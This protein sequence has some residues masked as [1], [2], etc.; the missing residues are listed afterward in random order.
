MWKSEITLSWRTFLFLLTVVF[1]GTVLLF[2]SGLWLF[3]QS[4][5]F[6][7][8]KWLQQENETL[9]Q[10]EAQFQT[11]LETLQNSVERMSRF[12]QKLRLLLGL[13]S[14][15]KEEVAPDDS[16]SNFYGGIHRVAFLKE[17]S[18]S[19][20]FYFL[21]DNRFRLL[22]LPT[23]M[24]VRGRVTSP[25]GRRIDPISGQRDFHRGIDIA[26]SEGTPIV[27]AAEGKIHW[28]GPSRGLG[29]TVMVY[30]GYGM[31][32]LYAHA[33]QIFVKN[34]QKVK[35]GELLASVGRSGRS[36]G[37]HLHYEVLMN[38]TPVNPRLYFLDRIL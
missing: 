32:T 14:K 33:E 26:A 24:P 8:R 28:A 17:Q 36:T 23:R 3:S 30:H 35:R 15:A 22:T 6:A 10:K 27:A 20:L 37:S 11:R 21:N 16:Q 12:E 29:N 4:S 9:K 7:D 13:S 19:E 31:M 5:W 1:L 38:G 18:F 2:G 34:G 25:F